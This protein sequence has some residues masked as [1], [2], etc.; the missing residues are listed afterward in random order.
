[1]GGDL[2][3][4]VD[5]I[6]CV[7]H[8]EGY[9]LIKEKTY[10]GQDF[11]ILFDFEANDFTSGGVFGFQNHEGKQVAFILNSPDDEQL[12][13]DA[14]FGS[15]DESGPDDYITYYHIVDGQT[16]S[17]KF[18]FEQSTKTVQ[19]KVDNA[20]ISSAVTSGY[21]FVD[22]FVFCK[23]ISGAPSFDG[24]ISNFK[25]ATAAVQQ[26]FYHL[27]DSERDCDAPTIHLLHD[28]TFEECGALCD[29]NSE[30]NEFEAYADRGGSQNKYH[31]GDCFLIL[32]PKNKDCA[33]FNLDHYLK[34]QREQTTS[35]LM[36]I[37]ALP[38]T[39][40]ICMLLLAFIGFVA[41][42]VKLLNML[43][44]HKE[45]YAVIEEHEI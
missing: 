9:T 4:S 22:E 45:D 40:Q 44:N 7:E 26:S 30:C 1:M 11:T 37:Q 43:Y 8:P 35:M 15:P 28:R 21:S 16:Y 42:I 3:F 31:P 34:K 39:S 2:Y 18:T 32:R 23:G 29:S 27:S 12:T 10:L 24:T 5:S 17:V 25:L 33:D 20:L 41:I 19:L 38:F 14:N 6:D 13:L 36:S